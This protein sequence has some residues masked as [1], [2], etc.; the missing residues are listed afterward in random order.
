MKIRM[1]LRSMIHNVKLWPRYN[2]KYLGIRLAALGIKAAP[3]KL[4]AIRLMGLIS[5]LLALVCNIK[6]WSG[7]SAFASHTGSAAPRWRYILRYFVQTATDRVW[8]LA[9][10]EA[11]PELAEGIRIEGREPLE[12]AVSEGKGA[13]V[14]GAHYGPMLYVFMLNTLGL[15][16]KQLIGKRFFKKAADISRLVP[17]RLLSKKFLA[18]ADTERSLMAK[19]GER[20]I[21]EHIKGGGVAFMDIDTPA[22]S[23]KAARAEFFGMPMRFSRFPFR[24][25]LAYDA[26]LFFTLF[27][28]TE[29][30]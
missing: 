19:G 16:V 14:V 18:M 5:G 10:Y 17:G 15:D 1:R 28:K 21:V 30:G 9:L 24:L 8:G 11:S 26:P 20:G 22:Q 2:L 13:V 27:E 6:R 29:D 12:R 23:R 3:S 25:A 7:V 4:S